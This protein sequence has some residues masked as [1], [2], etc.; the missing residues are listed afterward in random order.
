MKYYYKNIYLYK[1][2]LIKLL[3]PVNLNK[4]NYIYILIYKK[5]YLYLII[6]K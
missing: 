2:F 3:L 5:F 6:Y 1:L 4:K